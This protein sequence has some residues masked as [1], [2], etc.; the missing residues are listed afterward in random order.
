MP[1]LSPALDAHFSQTRPLG[2]WA[3]GLQMS[4]E[5]FHASRLWDENYRYELV[6][7]VL[8]VS[9]P[10]DIGERSLNDELGYLLLDYKH[11]HALGDHLDQTV[12]EQSV[13]TSAGWRRMDRAIWAGYGR[14]IDPQHDVPTIAVEFV[15]R[16]S[17][18]RHR[19]FVLKRA[20]YQEIGVR[21]YWVI[22]RFESTLNVFRGNGPIVV[23]ADQSYVS[24]FLPGLELPI[25]RILAAAQHWA[26]S[27]EESAQDH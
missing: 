2:L 10:P 22:D 19:D 15:S 16:S 17:R 24:E 20:E 11:R 18:D 3:N 8:I 5:E 27:S 4:A 14:P 25:A 26:E 7:G 13:S 1:A 23:T 12:S 6:N 9:P 21:E